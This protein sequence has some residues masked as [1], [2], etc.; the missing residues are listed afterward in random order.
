MLPV[1]MPAIGTWTPRSGVVLPYRALAG[2][3]EVRRRHRLVFGQRYGAPPGVRRGH[4]VEIGKL[5]AARQR[6]G[7]LGVIIEPGQAGSGVVPRRWAL[8]R[9]VRGPSGHG[10]RGKLAM[11]TKQREKTSVSQAP[12]P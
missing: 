1:L 11:C 10:R 8:R 12:M 2:L 7:V 9:A 4:A 3:L 6:R 5:R